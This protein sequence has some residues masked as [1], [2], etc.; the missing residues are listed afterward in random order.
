[1]CSGSTLIRPMPSCTRVTHNPPLEPTTRLRAGVFIL[2]WIAAQRHNVSRMRLPHY[3]VL[4]TALSAATSVVAEP[5]ECRIPGTKIH[6]VADYCMSKLETDDEIAASSCI[7]EEVKRA[8]MTDCA[9]KLHYK[10][11]MCALAISRNQRQDDIDSCLA[12]NDFVGATV[13]KG[14]VG[15]G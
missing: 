15:G 9:A 1:M 13:R 8:F 11:M 2:I 4:L 5:S 7:G 6:W 14:G 3:V 12:D 10:R